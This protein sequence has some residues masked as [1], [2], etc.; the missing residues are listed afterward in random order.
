MVEFTER[1]LGWGLSRLSLSRLSSLLTDG[2]FTLSFAWS[3]TWLLAASLIIQQHHNQREVKFCCLL[4]PL[5]KTSRKN[6][7]WLGCVTCL[8]LTQSLRL[9]SWGPVI[10]PS[11]VTWTLLWP[12]KTSLIR[13]EEGLLDWQQEQILYWLTLICLEVCG[14]SELATPKSVSLPCTDYF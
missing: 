11:W 13:R 9:G 5:L 14:R 10:S 12:R 2:Y 6:S 3:R 8:P 4:D 1:Q 7:Y